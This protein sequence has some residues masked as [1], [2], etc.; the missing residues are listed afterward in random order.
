MSL[1]LAIVMGIAYGQ[2][3]ESSVDVSSWVPSNTAQCSIQDQIEVDRQNI[4]DV[5]ASRRDEAIQ[6]LKN[7][8][9]LLLSIRKFTDL[10]DQSRAPLSVGIPSMDSGR[11]NFKPYLVRAVS[12]STTNRSISIHWCHQ[13]LLVFSGSLGGGRPTKDPILV[14]LAS[15]PRKVFLSYMAMK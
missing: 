13:D 9:V 8:N 3:V 1:V 12:T 10:A 5:K 2:S 6:A 11:S 14:F 15:K 7:K 4:F